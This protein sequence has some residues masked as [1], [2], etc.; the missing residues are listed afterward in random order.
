MVSQNTRWEIRAMASSALGLYKDT[1]DI[2][3][4]VKAL[5]DT[6]KIE[7]SYPTN[8][9]TA[10]PVVDEAAAT[11]LTFGYEVYI[12]SISGKYKIREKR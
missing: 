5:S 8:I 2:P 10:H 11:L 6:A 1:L 7:F 12:D 3:I 9:E 4:L